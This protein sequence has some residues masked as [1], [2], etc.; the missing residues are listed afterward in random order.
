MAGIRRVLVTG[1]HGFL[2][3]HLTAALL[4]RGY[5]VTILKREGSDLRRIG[6]LMDR[7]TPLTADLRDPEQVRQAVQTAAPDAILHLAA[8]YAVEHTPEQ[9]GIMVDTN[10]RG[11]VALLEAA[12]LEKT[13]LLVNT[14]TCTVYRE[15][16]TP[17]SEKDP[18]GPQNLYDLTKLQ[19]E[20]ACHFYRDR[21]GVPSVTLRIFP[22]YGPG[23]NERRL[24]PS[25]IR[26]LL[27]GESPALTSGT[28]RWDF[29][30]VRDIAAAYLAVLS[31][32]DRALQGEIF[33]VATGDART[34]REAVEQ[35]RTVLGSGTELRWGLVPHRRN[36]VWLN[37]G[38]PEKIRSMLGW[39]PRVPL[40][41]GLA[42]TVAWFRD[43]P[44]GP[45]G[46]G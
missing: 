10:V 37:S 16:E 40:A 45:G 28:Q 42:E 26:A 23:D 9:V 8:Y 11:A 6:H 36:E 18:V 27:S 29:V 34:V 25:V 43:H 3:S 24:I 33:N 1:A 39:E 7:I 13:A 35:V 2:G 19:A 44:A 22:P 14:S 4:D 21:F 5:R 38:N 32:P 41:Q 17:R 46:L 12:R 20:E 31:A 15:R 30:H